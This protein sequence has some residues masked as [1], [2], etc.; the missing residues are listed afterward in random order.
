[1]ADTSERIIILSGLL[2][3]I[4]F[5][6]TPFFQAQ[7][8]FEKYPT[9]S[10]IIFR[11]G[12]SV[13]EYPNELDT[14][15]GLFTKDMVDKAPS[16]TSLDFT[17][18]EMDEIKQMM[19]EIDFFSYPK[20]YQPTIEGKIIATTFPYYVYYLKY[21][22]EFGIRVVKWNDQHMSTGDPEYYNLNQLARLIISIIQEKPEFQ[23]LPQPTSA[24]D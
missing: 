24:Y 22:D 14:F 13:A 5:I 1:M 15:R 23:K 20:N 3:A 21:Y 19:V 10:N 12:I 16:K 6:S 8:E 4:L 18:E 9:T 17:Q 11:Y 7:S 2:L